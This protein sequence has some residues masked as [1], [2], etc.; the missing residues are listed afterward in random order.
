MFCFYATF[1]LLFA[2]IFLLI[3]LSLSLQGNPKKR[4]FAAIRAIPEAYSFILA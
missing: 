2:A 3:S 1:V 4:I